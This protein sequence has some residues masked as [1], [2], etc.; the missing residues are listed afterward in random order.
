MKVYIVVG[1]KGHWEDHVTWNEA[2]FLDKEKAEAYKNELNEIYDGREPIPDAE[3]IIYAIDER[4]GDLHDN[5]DLE[6]P[7]FIRDN[8]EQT[9]KNNEE[10]ERK[11]DE[12]SLKFL[13]QFN[14]SYTIETLRKLETWDHTRTE[15][16]S[17]YIEETET[18]DEYTIEQLKQIYEE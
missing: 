4:I 12:I 1:D 13:K 6:Y 17:F 3:D 11:V 7:E 15:D 2:V 14:P 9:K 5:G 18:K 10:Y 16:V 8:P